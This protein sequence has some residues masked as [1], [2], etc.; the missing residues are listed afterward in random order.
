M[1]MVEDAK[2]ILLQHNVIVHQKMLNDINNEISIRTQKK[3]KTS[4][5]VCFLVDYK[6]REVICYAFNLFYKS[7]KFPFSIH[8]EINAIT[9][10]YRA[11]HRSDKNKLKSKKVLIVLKITKSGK[12]GNSKPCQGCANYINNNLEN[13]NLVNIYFSTQYNELEKLETHDMQLDI[14]RY[15]SGSQFYL[16][17]KV[18]QKLIQ[19]TL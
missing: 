16:N 8:S 4:N 7:D 12:L 13:L 2:N 6:S 9:K 14:F 3:Q 5:H 17:K 1:K 18:D 15:S 11:K 19:K 10:Y